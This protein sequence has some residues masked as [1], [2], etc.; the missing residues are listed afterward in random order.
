MTIPERIDDPIPTGTAG[1]SPVCCHN[2][3]DA[4]EEV[5]V[6]RLDG[7]AAETRSIPADQTRAELD[8]LAKLLRAE[9]VT[10]HRPEPTRHER[11]FE[12]PDWK[13]RGFSA[14]CPR[15]AVIVVGNEL[16][17]TP[18][19]WRARYYETDALRPLFLSYFRAGARWSSAPRPDLKDELFEEAEGEW[20]DDAR[21]PMFVGESE[22][23]LCAADVVRCGTDL[24]AMRTAGTNLAGIEWLRR[25]LGDAHEVHEITPR[26]PVGGMLDTIFLPLSPGEFLVRDHAIDPARLPDV[27]RAGTIRIAPETSAEHAGLA[28][29]VLLLD[30]KRVLVEES[31][32]SMI[33]ALR[34]WGY[35]PRPVPLA[36]YAALGGSIRRA[37]LDIRRRT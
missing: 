21:P 31:Q 17:E 26:L 9:G 8:A 6:G 27:V 3:W 22:P 20:L 16:I 11:T 15:D 5:V 37:T 34:E 23:V 19:A 35:D 30:P 2:E 7:A 29:N 4:L 18:L 28:M 32:S 12:T 10:V 13:E 1:P 14:A 36:G 25:H 24:F 33:A